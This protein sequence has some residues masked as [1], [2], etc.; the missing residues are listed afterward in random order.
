MAGISYARRTEFMALITLAAAAVNV[1]L[2]FALIPPYGMVG[3][4]IANAVAYVILTTLYYVVAQRLYYTAYE[5]RKLVTTV[6]LATGLGAVGLVRIHSLTV[7]LPV[8]I[9]VLAAFP[10]LLWLRT[11]MWTRSH[12][13]ARPKWA[14]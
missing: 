7:A 8:K 6:A 5:V 1:G 9:G 2:N 12:S 3:A 14:S 11:Q 4:A 13:L 10:V